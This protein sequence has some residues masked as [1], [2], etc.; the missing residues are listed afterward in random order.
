MVAGAD[1]RFYMTYMT[2]MTANSDALVNLV[3]RPDA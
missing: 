2:Y 3:I 1:G